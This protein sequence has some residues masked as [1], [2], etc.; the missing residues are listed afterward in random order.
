MVLQER[1]CFF[2]FVSVNFSFY[3]PTWGGFQPN[4]AGYQPTWSGFQPNFAFISQRGV[5]FSQTLLLSAN[6][7]R[8]SAKLCFYQ[9][10]WSGFQPNFAFISQRGAD[11]SQTSDFSA[12]VKLLSAKRSLPPLAPFL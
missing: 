7:R 10:T 11:F 3:Q 5:D 2:S 1:G 4:F 8:I 12:K 9:P 6:V